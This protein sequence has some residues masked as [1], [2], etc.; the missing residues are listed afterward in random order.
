MAGQKINVRRR[1]ASL[2]IVVCLGLVVVLVCTDCGTSERNFSHVT[3]EPEALPASVRDQFGVMGVELRESSPGVDFEQP[4]NVTQAMAAKTSQAFVALERA[5]LE[6]P[7]GVDGGP[8]VEAARVQTAREEH[9]SPVAHVPEAH[10]AGEHEP[11]SREHSRTRQSPSKPGASQTHDDDNPGLGDVLADEAAQLL[12]SLAAAGAVGL[13]E[14]LF[15]G[16]PTP[17]LERSEAALRKALR[18]DP[19]EA[20]LQARLSQMAAAK[21]W[22]KLVAVP[23]GALPASTGGQRVDQRNL[24]ALG[25]DSLLVITVSNQRFF[26]VRD[27]D[28]LLGY[29]AEVDIRVIRASDGKVLHADALQYLS[30]E[31]HFTKWADHDAKT[32]RADMDDAQQLITACILEELFAGDPAK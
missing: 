11:A 28:P 13:V 15:A 9:P 22:K 8:I 18:D 17:E 21:G 31:R 24:S 23:Q 30:R 3:N 7:D 14:G 4:P 25:I 1:G 5:R 16:V 29:A 27:M 19:L 2:D 6:H 10:Q 12:F 32:F 20:G 26:L